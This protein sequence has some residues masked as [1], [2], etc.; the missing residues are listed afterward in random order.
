MV[1]KKTCVFISG[2]GSNLK[3]LIYNSRD[4]N[5]PIKISLVICNNEKAPGITYAKKY[6]IPYILVDSKFK[7]YENKV[8]LSLKRYKI[9]FICLAGYMKII[10]SKLIKNYQKKI[11]N[12][13]PSLLPKFKGLNT[14]SR[15]LK[16]NEIEGGCTVHYVNEKLDSGS[17]I[18]KKKFFINPSDDE[19]NLKKKTQILEYRALPEAIIKIFRNV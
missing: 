3:N 11:I 4:S 13:H 1:K 19:K 7:N 8:L 6:K 16:N 17:T 2:Q 5:F 14:Y 10:S 12:I 15:M 18:I 9:T